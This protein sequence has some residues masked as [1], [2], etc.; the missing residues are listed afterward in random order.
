MGKRVKVFLA[1]DITIAIAVLMSG[2]SGIVL[3]LAGPGGYQ[4]GQ[5]P[6][7]GMSILGLSR[8]AWDDLHLWTSLIMGAGVLLH[9]ALHWSWIMGV[10][11][12][13]SAKQ[14]TRPAPSLSNQTNPVEA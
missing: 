3:W 2:V 9:L 14:A 13:L 6:N 11:R 1:V 5:N 4:G 10:S 12:R 7:Y 8:G